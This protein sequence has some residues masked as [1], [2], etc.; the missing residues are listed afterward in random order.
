MKL[1]L[2][3]V[4]VLILFSTYSWAGE[5]LKY[6]TYAN[7]AAEF[8]IDVPQTLLYPQGES[9]NH[10]GQ[11]FKSAD[12]NAKLYTYGKGNIDEQD[13]EGLFQEALNPD[14]KDE[15][16]ITYKNMGSNWFVITG[17]HKDKVFYTKSILSK[18]TGLILTFY[19]E[20]PKTQKSLYDK[21]TVKMSKSF[22]EL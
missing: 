9:G 3:V 5:K 7:S 19:F 1:K 20:Y 17:F 16:V 21:V 11:L 10:M 14:N 2:I 6:T 15:K 13:I 12:N 4:L 18:A 22:K 8:S